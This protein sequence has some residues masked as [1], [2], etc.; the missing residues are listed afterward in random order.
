MLV[1]DFMTPEPKTVSPSDDAGST[2]E[3]MRSLN[4][5]QCPVV[6]NGS[7]VG[8]VTD[9]NLRTAL[10]AGGNPNVKDIMAVNPV[11][12]LDYASIEG[13]AR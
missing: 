5:R 3:L 6:E 4:F 13:A 1:K 12:I 10:A 7:L 9:R 2:L 8:I 11:T